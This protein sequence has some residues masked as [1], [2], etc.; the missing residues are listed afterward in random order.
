[1]AI[2]ALTYACVGLLAAQD[3][4]RLRE[5]AREMH[6]HGMEAW[7]RGAGGEDEVLPLSCTPR[8]KLR[9]QRGTLDDALGNYSLTLVDA[10]DTYALMGE[11][12]DFR[13][14]VRTVIATVSFDQNVSVS[15]FEATI[16]VLGG[17]LSS[18]LL[19]TAPGSR[20]CVVDDSGCYRGELLALAHD[21][22]VRLLPAFRTATGLPSSTV[23]LQTGRRGG[24]SKTC[25]AAAGSLVLEFALLSRLTGDAS[26]EKAARGAV[27]EIWRRRSALDLV[28][29]EI[30]IHSGAWQGSIAG[31][32]AGIDSFYEYLMKGSILLHDAEWDTMWTKAKAAVRTHVAKVGG[33]WLNVDR[34]T[35]TTIGLPSITSL[36]AFWPG[37]LAA[38]AGAGELKRAQQSYANLAAVWRTFN[39]LPEAFLL[40]ANLAPSAMANAGFVSSVALAN[41]FGY[42]SFLFL[43]YSFVCTILLFSL[44]AQVPAPS[45]AHRE[46]VSSVAAH[47]RR[48]IRYRSREYD[49]RCAAALQDTVRLR[50]AR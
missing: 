49:A 50:C 46:L 31:I 38:E 17:L 18:H 44:S 8:S 39:G 20:Y 47:A 25:S 12:E 22:G 29:N 41:S 10:M 40:R 16:R 35:G 45:G 34:T 1:M 27:R 13:R 28:G 23:H 26:F 19:V 14:A 6:L 21:L 24:G 36:S 30:D 37:V 33:W 15:V 5:Q 7:W 3:A 9:D 48:T 32:G 42:Y 4:L 11:E 43:I 2:L